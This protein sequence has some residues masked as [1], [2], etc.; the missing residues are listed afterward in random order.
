VKINPAKCVLGKERIKLLGYE[1]SISGTKSLPEKTI[2]NFRKPI[3]VRQLR[4]FLGMINFY[5]KFI[6]GA[7]KD[8]ATLHD[9]LKGPKVKSRKQ[10]DWT[11]EQETAFSNC[12]KSL[13]GAT[14]LAQSIHQPDPSAEL[15]LTTDTVVGA[16]IE[17]ISKEGAQPLA[18]LSKKLN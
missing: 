11:K 16:V 9:M 17:Q 4:Q 15:I 5:R 2:K 6:P 1:V 12:K 13:E 8:Q 3:T 10:I 7:A 14:E 18:F